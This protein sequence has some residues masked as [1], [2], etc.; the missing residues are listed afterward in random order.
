MLATEEQAR[1]YRDIVLPESQNAVGAAVAAYQS[2]QIP[3]TDLLDIY[4][5]AQLARLEKA[6]SVFNC[7]AARADLEVVGEI[8]KPNSLQ[9]LP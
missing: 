6:Q 4:R 2:D 8:L 7:L 1:E 9:E 3:L 5:T